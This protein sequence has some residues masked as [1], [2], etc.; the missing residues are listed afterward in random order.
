MG[1]VAIHLREGS[2]QPWRVNW[3][4]LAVEAFMTLQ[5]ASRGMDYVQDRPAQAP[6]ASLSTMEAA[7]PLWIW[8]L[9]FLLGSGAVFFGLYGGWWSP[10]VGGHA[11][12]TG[13]YGAFAYGVLDQAPV[14]NLWLALAGGILLLP[15]LYTGTTRW[16]HWRWLRIASGSVL[17]LLGGWVV[18]Y[19]LGY[20]FR[21]GTSLMFAAAMHCSFA[22]GVAY[23]A[24]WRPPPLA[25]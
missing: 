3:L 23:I 25:A 19:G 12:L 17:T 13:L 20:D 4:I 7:L 21:T 5:S 15:G 24:H 11:A 14:R 6:T 18:S 10:I 2:W 8:G 9:A 1:K 16:T 22:I